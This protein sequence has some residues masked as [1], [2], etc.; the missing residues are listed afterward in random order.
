MALGIS[1][2]VVAGILASQF[3]HVAGATPILA[4]LLCA[5]CFWRKRNVALIGIVA[6]LTRDAL[7]G[8][9]WFTVVRVAAVLGVVGVVWLVRLRPSFSSLLTGLGLSAPVYHLTLSVGD[10]LTHTCSTAPFTWQGLMTTIHTSVPYFYRSFFGD[11]VFTS[12]FMGLYTFAGYVVTLRWPSLLPHE[13]TPDS[14]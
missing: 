1:F 13:A 9:S 8:I 7:A 2:A 12:A 5:A 14:V 11:L 6:M 4:A 10:W 3:T